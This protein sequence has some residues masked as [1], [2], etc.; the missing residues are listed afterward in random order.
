MFILLPWLSLLFSAWHVSQLYA[1]HQSRAKPRSHVASLGTGLSMRSNRCGV[2]VE[3][4]SGVRNVWGRVVPAARPSA[5]TRVPLV[6]WQAFVMPRG[7]GRSCA[8]DLTCAGLG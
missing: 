7:A 5:S 3:Y 6:C 2:P 1:A 4:L 8:L